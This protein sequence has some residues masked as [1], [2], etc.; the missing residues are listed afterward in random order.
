MK[1]ASTEN[2]LA[3]QRHLLALIVETFDAIELKPP[4]LERARQLADYAD[5]GGTVPDPPSGGGD[6][7]AVP[8]ESWTQPEMFEDAA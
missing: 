7:P 5:L 6:K 2:S 1:F 8:P 4:G 3:E